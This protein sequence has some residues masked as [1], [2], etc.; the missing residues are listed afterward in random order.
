MAIS[1]SGSVHYYF[2]WPEG[3]S[4]K[5]S[6]SKITPGIDVRGDRGIVIAPPSV[7]AKGNY[8][9]LND[10][11]LADAPGWL[12]DLASA[13]KRKPSDRPDNLTTHAPKG[14]AEH[15]GKGVEPIDLTELRT[16]LFAVDPNIYDN[17]LVRLPGRAQN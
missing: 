10:T 2:N 6:A 4:I 7:T 3:A 5:N 11:P 9:W 8:S 14:A 1:P 12:I 13:R 17:Q 15:A 16:A